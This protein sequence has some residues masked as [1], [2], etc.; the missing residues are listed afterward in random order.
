MDGV[1]YKKKIDEKKAYPKR[2]TFLLCSLNSEQETLLIFPT[3]K[4]SK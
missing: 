2:M 1:I 4:N 3:E